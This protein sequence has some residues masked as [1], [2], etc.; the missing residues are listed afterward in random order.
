MGGSPPEPEDQ[1]PGARRFLSARSGHQLEFLHAAK[2]YVGKMSGFELEWLYRKPYDPRPGHEQFYLQVYAVM[3]LLK[4]MD[5]PAG[6][7]ILEVA[8]GPGWVTKLLMLLGYE[9]D[10]VEPCADLVAIARERIESAS[11]HYR[12]RE[13]PRVEF[14]VDTV[15]DVELP[16]ESFDAV[17][18]HDALH[19]VLDEEA[20][21]A[22]SFRFLKPGGV[23]GISEDAWRPGNRQQESELEEEIARFGTHESPF[24]QP[25]LDS[26]LLEAGFLDVQRYHSVNG[27]FPAEMGTM[28]LEEAAQTRA[29]ISNNLTAWKP[30]FEGPTTLDPEAETKARIVILDRSFD[31]PNRKATLHLRLI[32]AGA[33]VWLHRPRKAGWVSLALRSE[34]LGSP[35]SCEAQPRHR[36]PRSVPPG[37]EVEL[38]LVYYL[39]EGYERHSWR[40]DLVNEG[41]FWFSQRGS[42]AAE[43]DFR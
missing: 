25:Y 7:R 28:S 42:S 12:L 23:L 37:G 43:C 20:V 3:N 31:R 13:T 36:L 38:R 33:T 22:R 35:D 5:V 10:A 34:P 9:V 17:L 11:K 40:I 2:D 29:S 21:L 14:H 24:A 41:L 27:F 8:S 18:F 19:H 6:G 39:P 1:P 15:E 4:A 26:L 30:A 16:P 32:N